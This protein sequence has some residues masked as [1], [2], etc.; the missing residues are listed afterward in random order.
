MHG[1]IGITLVL[2]VMLMAPPSAADVKPHA[3]ISD[4]AV[5]QQGMAA[6]IWGKAGDGE[7]V[8]VR[9]QDQE[10]STT[11]S[12]GRWMVRLKPLRPGGPF[13]MTISGE[14]TI[15]LHNILVGEVWICSGQ[16]N[17]RHQV[18]QSENP[19]QVIAASKDPM[20][21]L[22]DVPQ[23]DMPPDEL[24]A[25]W[26]ECGPDTVAGFSAV[27]YFF[28]RELRKA[29]K[30]PV[31]LICSAVGATPAEAWTS[32]R[33]LRDKSELHSIVENPEKD[34]RRPACLYNGMIAPLQPYAIR[35]VIWYQ[36]EANTGRAYQYRTL[37][38]TMIQNWREDWGQGDFPF[39]FVQ[40]APYG[41]DDPNR[42]YPFWAE[43]REAQL[44]TSLRVPNTAM[45]VITDLGDPKEIH[46]KPKGPVGARLA[47]AARAIA[48]G[49]RIVYS[50]PIFEKMQIKGDCAILSFK[51]VGS[52]LAAK[53]GELKGFTVTGDD[54]KFV[55]A[56]AVI[57]GKNVVVWSTEVP[58]PAAV[59]YGWANCP[60][61]NLFNKEG[62][63]ASPFRT[64]DFP[65]V[66]G[67]R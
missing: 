24:K 63:P 4:G 6:P 55:N 48:Y 19:E 50:G 13:T 38:P 23:A 9:F 5:L 31:G 67:Q 40:L 36:G 41:T 47:L 46:P 60:A 51:H 34:L 11:A 45:A 14:N 61:V 22:F 10:V 7:K 3:L 16:S 39:L 35:G 17:M 32:L 56:Q 52:G 21:R 25:S 66:T 44:F 8:T 29:L 12:H 62:L 18:Y 2:I 65:M 26:Q 57:Q 58:H 15:E 20:L 33:A 49:E 59:R 1:T 28:G 42:P 54:G 64:D 43:L 27:G 30:A 37:F 53:D